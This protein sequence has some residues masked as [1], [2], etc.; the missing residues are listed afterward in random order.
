MVKSASAAMTDGQLLRKI[1][2][3]NGF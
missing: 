3:I 2:A 1:D